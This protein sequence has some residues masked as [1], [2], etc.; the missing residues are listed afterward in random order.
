L[1]YSHPGKPKTFLVQIMGK[2][3]PKTN[4]SL[5]EVPPA[6]AAPSAPAAAVVDLDP[7]T[8]PS[9]LLSP[10]QPPELPVTTTKTTTTATLV[11]YEVFYPPTQTIGTGMNMLRY[12]PQAPAWHCSFSHNGEWLAACFGAPTPCVR[13]WRYCPKIQSPPAAAATTTTTTT[14]KATKATTPIKQKLSHKQQD[15]DHHPSSQTETPTK[16]NTSSGS[17]ILHSTLEGI[18]ERTIRCVAFAPLAKTCILAAASFDST[19]TLWEYSSSS[20]PADQQWECTTQLEGHENEV[21]YVAWNA[22]GSLLATCG[23][24]KSI[25]LWETFFNGTIGGSS[26]DEV[27]CIAVLNGHEGDVKCV[28]FAPNHQ[29]SYS[30]GSGGS[31][32][33]VISASYD[34]SI[35]IWAAEDNTGGGDWYCVAS[36]SDVHSD[37]IW[38]LA[39]SPG[40]GRFISAS[41]D[42][43][44]AIWK[45]Y[46]STPP[47]P[48]QQCHHVTDTTT[49]TKAITATTPTTN[50]T[51]TT[52]LWKCVGK[53]E[54]AHHT[55]TVYSVAYA[56]A[57]AGHGRIA[58]AGADNRIQI[59]REVKESTSDQ[60]L[61][62]LDALVDTN[63]GD[64]NCVCWHPRDG[65][66]LCSAGDDGTVR[67]WKF[68]P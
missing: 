30:S 11:E 21:K 6:T 42:G 31:D 48:K 8:D 10:E 64:V 46:Y 25:W 20:S 49:T 57:R 52:G 45:C 22:T 27:E 16:S 19:V 32:E 68:E 39:L 50:T 59:Y 23:R 65:S 47:E 4:T 54:G 18:H 15:Q 56:P 2:D 28:Q 41:A 55:S 14:T 61:F 66:L 5:N 58:S 24:D 62:D 51:T 1:C 63:H 26:A 9:Q 44:L 36:I 67:L 29:A 34:N 7:L 53:L 13:V 37:T 33:I 35:K 3:H 43:S 17:W 12:T 60:P 40:G 38:S